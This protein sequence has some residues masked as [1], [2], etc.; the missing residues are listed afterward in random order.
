MKLLKALLLLT[1][2]S[3]FMSVKTPVEAVGF[4]RT[5]IVSGLTAAVKLIHLPDGRMLVAEKAGKVRVIK[6]G[7]LLSAPMLDISDHVNNYVDRGLLSIAIDPDFEEN[8]Y[9][10][11]LYTHQ[12]TNDPADKNK[13]NRLVRVQL[14][15]ATADEAVP[16]INPPEAIILG[17]VDD[18]FCGPGLDCMP[19]NSY[20][21]AI[22]DIVFDEEEN[23]FLSVGDGSE[24][25][26]VDPQALRAQNPDWLLG[27]VLHINREGEGLD[28]NPYYNGDPD[29]PRSKVYQMGLRNP[30]RLTLHPDFGLFTT[31][32]GWYLWEEVNHGG[33][34]ANFGW[35][36]FEGNDPT[37]EYSTNPQILDFCQ[38]MYDNPTDKKPL[39]EY[40]HEGGGGAAIGGAFYDGTEYPEE[41]RNNFF[42]ADHDKK[43]V[44]RLSF[45]SEGEFES[46]EN[47][48]A[49]VQEP[50]MVFSYP[51]NGDIGWISIWSGKIIRVSYNENNRA[52]V[53]VASSNIT[54]GA[55]PLTVEFDGSLSSDP[56]EDELTFNWDFGDGS[57]S[58]EVNPVH[59]YSSPGTMS[60]T[61]TVSDGFSEATD[62]IT[63]NVGDEAPVISITSPIKDT[64]FVA[65]AAIQYSGS[66]VDTSGNPIPAENVSW[67]LIIHHNDHIH[68]EFDGVTGYAGSKTLPYHADNSFYE[69]EFTATDPNNGLTSKKTVNFYVLPEGS[70]SEIVIYA[71]GTLAHDSY[72]TME[73]LV[74]DVVVASYENVMGD[75]QER[76]FEQFAYNHT[77]NVKA[78]QIKVR[79][80]NDFYSQAEGQDRNLMVDKVIVDGITYETED[81]NVFS[82]GSW[83]ADN[84]CGPGYKRSEELACNGYFSYAGGSL[85]EVFAAGTPAGGVYPNAQLV[86]NNVVVATSNNIQGDIEN[87]DF[88]RIAYRY[89]IKLTESDK[90]QVKFTNDLN[91]NGEDRNLIVDKIR[92]DGI[93]YETESSSVFSFGSWSAANSCGPGYKLSET[94][95][96]NGYFEYTFSNPQGSQIDIYAAGTPAV[97][98]YPNIELLIDDVV[99]KTFFGVGSTF[100]PGFFETLKYTHR[101]TVLPS[102]IKVRFINDY[103]DA[104]T[105]DNRDAFIDR[106]SID[107]VDYQSEDPSVYSEGSWSVGNGCGGG[108]KASEMLSCNNSY[109][110]Y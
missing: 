2:L 52:P 89:P 91:E 94:L 60:V 44:R 88:E 38:D 80:T 82:V 75:P 21:H 15:S 1:L 11:L 41:Y 46:A 5:E 42:F 3:F 95:A 24:Y 63:I 27:K 65:P 64:N 16:S 73:L 37:T 17:S 33:V 78:E 59:T 34:G 50:V 86:I 8:F 23:I 35:P 66:A 93:D 32:V 12:G 57:S 100:G 58:A 30:F 68:V 40:S 43:W 48:M 10:Y 56:D 25:D 6:D 76:M 109:F 85:I 9:L 99:V 47:F 31:D 84:D 106:I 29:A 97:G 20:S 103:Y 87:R 4:E 7:Q 67:K 102:Q 53:A 96:C 101:D 107:G 110:Q 92:V 45:T 13:T 26:F 98:V 90:I 72:P 28:S 61:L 18:P 51:D 69:L 71:A 14:P 49:D 19:I 79:F 39:Y 74:D 22:G 77:S 62:T 70:G 55:V 104:L 105:G 54:S 108:Y 36:C 83:S 81:Q